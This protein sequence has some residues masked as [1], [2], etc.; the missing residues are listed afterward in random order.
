MSRNAFSKPQRAYIFDTLEKATDKVATLQELADKYVTEP[1][2]IK[3]MLMRVFPENYNKWF[4]SAVSTEKRLT[5]KELVERIMYEIDYDESK[6]KWISEA[7]SNFSSSIPVDF[8]TEIYKKLV[9]AHIFE[10]IEEEYLLFEN[11]I[12]TPSTLS[13]WFTF[14]STVPNVKKITARKELDQHQERT[15]DYLASIPDYILF[16]EIV[17]PEEGEEDEVSSMPDIFNFKLPSTH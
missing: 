16:K 8:L 9:A 14:F 7:A 13:E 3:L 6:R 15:K 1:K 10:E 4:K 17:E 2:N 11:W 5:K 12:H